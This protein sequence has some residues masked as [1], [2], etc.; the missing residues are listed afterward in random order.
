M[1]YK[2][3]NCGV[4][5]DPEAKECPFCGTRVKR[6]QV[7]KNAQAERRSV[8]EKN[9]QEKMYQKAGGTGDQSFGAGTANGQRTQQTG[10]AGSQQANGSASGQ[11][12]SSTYI[13]PQYHNQTYSSNRRYS[14]QFNKMIPNMQR[15]T[16]T[17]GGSG[18]V[19]W[20]VFWGI[21]VFCLAIFA[22]MAFVFASLDK[23]T[24]TESYSFQEEKDYETSR[25]DS[26]D[27][28]KEDIFGKAPD[29]VTEEEL[30][31]IRYLYI[32]DDQYIMFSTKEAEGYR[33]LSQTYGGEMEYREMT[34]PLTA[35]ED[36]ACFPNLQVL[37]ISGNY[38]I[39]E[40]SAF[41]QWKDLKYLFLYDV[42]GIHDF[43]DLAGM[44]E[45]L[46]VLVISGIDDLDGITDFQNLKWLELYNTF[47]DDISQLS[48]MKNLEILD[49]TGNYDLVDL[50]PIRD[51]SNLTALY[52]S[53][54]RIED[55]KVIRDLP[56]LDTLTIDSTQVTDLGFLTGMESLT[57]LVLTN[58]YQLSDLTPLSELPGLSQLALS[59]NSIVDFAP[60]ENATG[61]T[62]LEISSS[63]LENIDF[64]NNM[65]NLTYLDLKDNY[66][67]DVSGLLDFP[68]LRYL[69]LTDN[70]VEDAGGLEQKEDLVVVGF[71]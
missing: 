31:S 5:L 57:S 18:K 36:L 43:R 28:L 9:I 46:E 25:E 32:E 1:D 33:E 34:T 37:Q 60:L 51:L 8:E 45:Q 22:I 63:G 35:V 53:G 13:G 65:S 66:I 48:G 11:D 56:L 71:D 2:C 64:L 21:L 14:Q 54:N 29:S 49:L 62:Y 67:S 12:Q 44:E 50:E 40:P 41:N 30:A 4:I 17:V 27:N 55:Y 38:Y 26:I 68:N 7:K 24:D 16:A 47:V 70:P 20:A 10:S 59:N 39:N 61:L 52:L 69:D 3:H 58:N 23:E 42:Y 15:N 19:V 6:G